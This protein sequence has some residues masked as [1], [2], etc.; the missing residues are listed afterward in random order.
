[1]DGAAKTTAK[2]PQRLSIEQLLPV[3]PRKERKKR[4]IQRKRDESDVAEA[5]RKL[6]SSRTDQLSGTPRE[7]DSGGR[8]SDVRNSIIHSS[9][10]STDTTP[11]K[12]P[13]TDDSYSYDD[14]DEDDP[15]NV[16]R[17][18]LQRD[19]KSK[20]ERERKLIDDGKRD[21]QRKIDDSDGERQRD[22]DDSD[23]E[24]DGKRD[25]DNDGNTGNA[26]RRKR[27]KRD[28]E[29][30]LIDDG[31][32]DDDDSDDDSDDDCDDEGEGNGKTKHVFFIDKATG[33]KRYRLDDYRLE[34]NI[35]TSREEGNV[36]LARTTATAMT[37][38]ATPP[39]RCENLFY[40][41]KNLST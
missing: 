2:P 23:G 28:R 37:T 14:S 1:M 38:A 29:Q 15:G 22:F 41:T 20:R 25:G 19:R 33:T 34:E 26:Q 32:R 3:S 10:Q 39:F 12:R 5:M 18:I 30:D 21:G 31:Q 24:R 27:N 6:I 9:T 13:R 40:G 11:P 7:F 35:P 36:H 16:M 8:A 17:D 4:A